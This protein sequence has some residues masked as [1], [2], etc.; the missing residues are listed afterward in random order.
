M[1]DMRDESRGFGE[2]PASVR[3]ASGERPASAQKGN[4]VWRV[5]TTAYSRWYAWVSGKMGAYRG[6]RGLVW[7]PRP[8]G[9]SGA[10]THPS[11]LAPITTTTHATQSSQPVH[12]V[13]DRDRERQRE[14]W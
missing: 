10:T 1:T 6:A 5:S 14:T 11:R 9:L 12:V 4:G 7:E 3:R 2:R 13:V 8:G